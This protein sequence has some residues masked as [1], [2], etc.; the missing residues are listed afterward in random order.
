M[1]ITY[2]T[3][4]SIGAG[5]QFTFAAAG[6]EYVVLSGVTV[7]S[8]NNYA[9]YGTQG[10]QSLRVDGTVMSNIRTVY[11]S[12]GSNDIAVGAEG[13][14]V[15]LRSD[16]GNANLF[17]VGGGSRLSNQGEISGPNI[18]GVMLNGGGNEVLNDGLILGSS[19]LFMGLTGN[20]DDRLVNNGTIS[21]TSYNA[22]IYNNRNN[23]G[24]FSEGD[25]TSIYNG[26]SGVISAISIQ[27]AGVAIGDADGLYGGDGSSVRNFGEISSVQ[28]Y[29]VD[30]FNMIAGEVAS[31]KNFGTISGGAGSFRG[32]QSDETVVNGGLM[33]G[34]VKLGGGDDTFKG[35]DGAVDGKIKGGSGN[36]T[37]I[38]SKSDNDILKGDGGKDTLKGR[39]GD[40][41]LMGGGGK[42]TLNGGRGD[43]ELKG[44]GGKDTFV[45]KK[46]QGSDVIEDFQNGKDKI[47]LSGFGF[48]NKNQA[49]NKFYELGS[50][51]DDKLVFDFKDTTIIVKG[52]DMGQLNNADIIV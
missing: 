45:F 23:N 11:L 52:I 6:D 8:T 21:A 29:G 33:V 22:T 3:T 37:L 19:G 39:G 43:D 38:G 4:D 36:D 26:A 48:K 35:R 27:G 5:V 16:S 44:G 17:L 51:S 47:D 9:I 2:Q 40:D 42:D 18:I 41:S 31:L 15:S 1:A 7:A 32:N 14:L 30:F 34:D 49:L 46:N 20:A 25:N 24:V 13:R 10:S 28:W 50:G 12:G